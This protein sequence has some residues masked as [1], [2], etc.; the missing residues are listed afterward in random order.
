ML[1]VLFLSFE[2]SAS[3]WFMIFDE[4]GIEAKDRFYIQANARTTAPSKVIPL[5]SRI[6][7]HDL[8]VAPLGNMSSV[9]MTS[10]LMSQNLSS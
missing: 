10:I 8:K 6:F 5:S 9:N 7:M 3:I 1:A 2:I 4:I